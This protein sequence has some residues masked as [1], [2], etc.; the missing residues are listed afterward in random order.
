MKGRIVVVLVATT[1][2][3]GAVGAAAVGFGGGS[4]NGTQAHSSLPPATAQ[5]TRQSLFDTVKDPG[6]LGYG[7]ETT[8][9]GKLQGTVTWLP[10]TGAVVHRGEALYRVD[11]LPVL[12]LY[13][14]LPVYRQLASGDEGA[15]VKQFEQELKALGY[16][17]FT[18]DNKY[19]S[20][21]ATAV[22]KWQKANGLTQT[23]VVEAGRVVYAPGEVRIASQKVSIGDSAQGGIVTTSGTARV[24]TVKL[25]V[26]DQRLA[27]KDTKVSVTL[28]D[29]TKV[30]GTIVKVATVVESGSGG[31]GDTTKIE[32][33][34]AL[35]DAS[36]ISGFDAATVDVMFTVSERKNVLVVPVAAL[37][38]LAEGG[39][40]VQ[41]V[42]GSS[43]RIVRVE[44]G[45][46][47]GGKVEVTAEGLTE[48]TTVGMPT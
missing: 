5:V 4:D 2:V 35:A 32:V 8:V 20:E 22:K 15:D 21:T 45:L 24:V 27:K 43:T 25:K 6:T 38:A 36:K 42:E 48:G 26:S 46:F 19:T 17:G 39:Y 18:V 29:G 30:D 34:I 44:V 47:S 12:L 37:L 16:T 40:G 9:A 33:T 28:P 7:R 3:V 14:S 1:A 13:G 31:S 41:V 23:G 11:N 10:D